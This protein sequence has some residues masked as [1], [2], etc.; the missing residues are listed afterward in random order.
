MQLLACCAI[1]EVIMEGVS[2]K[3]RGRS[4]VIPASL[5]L[6]QELTFLQVFELMQ[7][8]GVSPS[9]VTYGCLMHGCELQGKIDQAVRL[10]EEACSTGV[11]PS[12][13]CHNTLVNMFAKSNR[14]IVYF[15]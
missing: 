3:Q 14:S 11:F 13:E 2:F 10:Y 12:D 5:P 6:G 8:E 4:Q 1:S 7:G 9:A 15:Y